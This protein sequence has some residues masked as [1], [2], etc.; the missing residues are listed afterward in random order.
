MDERVKA[1]EDKRLEAFD[2]ARQEA[3]DRE[4]NLL[5]AAK[6][7]EENLEKL[8]QSKL[9]ELRNDQMQERSV[10]EGK[11]A[12][13]LQALEAAKQQPTPGPEAIQVSSAT[14]RG[15]ATVFLS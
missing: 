6:E 12:D 5:Q 15:F 11:V 9:D 1:V 10:L 4:E 7:R 14:R 3:Q 8:W 13:L 2:A